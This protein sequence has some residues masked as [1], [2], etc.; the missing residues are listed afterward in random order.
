[1]PEAGYKVTISTSEGRA[2]VGSLR[3]S[4]DALTDATKRSA[5]QQAQWNVR[6]AQQDVIKGVTGAVNV[7]RKA[8]EDLAKIQGVSEK[9]AK[10]LGDRAVQNTA[11]MREAAS[12]ASV[13]SQS[14]GV[15]VTQVTALAGAYVSLRSLASFISEST[16]L[17]A[18]Y[19]TLGVVMHTV[20]ENAGYATS[21]LNG[22]EASLERTGIAMLASRQ[23]VSQMIQAQMD[24]SSATKLAR[25]A[26]DAAVIGN[27]NSSEAF[28]R[29]TTA[30]QTAQPE[31]LRTMGIIVN[32]DEAYRK[33]AR[34][35]STTTDALTENQK[36]QA[37]VAASMEATK[38]IAGAYEA[39]MGTP[40]KQALSLE[41]YWEDFKVNL[42]ESFQP[43][44]KALI[45][46]TTDALKD[47]TEV[48]KDPS[49]QN[50]MK[51]WAESL[52]AVAKAMAEIGKWAGI[53]SQIGT[54]QEG[55]KLLDE[56]RVD[57]S[58]W[59]EF[60]SG[61]VFDFS[62]EN[63]WSNYKNASKRQQM[64]DA[65]KAALERERR[66][67]LAQNWGYVP[68]ESSARGG[69]PF[70]SDIPKDGEL[71]KL[72]QGQQARE[73]YDLK[74][75]ISIFLDKNK[76]YQSTS[77]LLDEATKTWTGERSNASRA[78][79]L[80]QAMGDSQMYADAQKMQAEADQKLIE[81]RQQLIKANEDVRRSIQGIVASA[82]AEQAEL[83]GDKYLSERIK[84]VQSYRDELAQLTDRMA[85]YKGEDRDALESSG[86]RWVQ[87][88]LRISE[89]R[90]ELERW[91]DTLS[92][93]GDL[94]SDLGRLSGSP[95]ASYQG[96][97]FKL[98]AQYKDASD[99]AK[100][101]GISQDLVD[102]AY[103]L[104]A[105]EAWQ[106]SYKGLTTIDG[107]AFDVRRAMLSREVEDFRKAGADET[108]LRIYAAQK[109]EDIAR[110]E[111]QTRQAYAGS[112]T[113]F[114]RGQVNIEL[115]LYQGA[116][117][118]ELQEWQDYYNDLKQLGQ[119]WMDTTKSGL[120]DLIDG[121]VTG[122]GEDAWKNMLANMRR[123][124]IQF[125]VDLAMDWAKAN[126]FK[127]ALGGMLGISSNETA[128]K[129]VE[130]AARGL[131]SQTV[132]APSS[133]SVLAWLGQ[134]V[135]TYTPSLVEEITAP[136]KQ[137]AGAVSKATGGMSVYLPEIKKAADWYGLPP[138]LIQS[139]VYHESRGNPNAVSGKGAMGLMQLMPGTAREMGVD[140][141]NPVENIWGGTKF[142]AMMK[143]RY[144]GDL[145]KALAAYNA[146][147]GAVDAGTVPSSTWKYNEKVFA[148]AVAYRSHGAADLSSVAALPGHHLEKLNQTFADSLGSMAKDFEQITGEKLRLTDGFRTRA[149]QEETYRNKPNLAAR[150]GYSMHEYGYAVD[151]DSAQAKQVIDL[152]NQGRLDAHGLD[153]LRGRTK[154]EPWHWQL[155]E[156]YSRQ[157]EIRNG[158]FVAGSQPYG[159]AGEEG[160]RAVA[161]AAS[162]YGLLGVNF[163]QLGAQSI[164][165]KIDTRG[166]IYSALTG[167][168][169]SYAWNT[170]NVTQASDMGS[171][172]WTA[173]TGSNVWDVSTSSSALS[174]LSSTDATTAAKLV[175]MGMSPDQAVTLVTGASGGSSTAQAVNSQTAQ[176]GTNFN[177]SD[178]LKNAGSG[179]WVDSLNQ[180]GF[181]NLGIG[182]ITGE[183]VG[184]SVPA[185][186]G[187]NATGWTGST[188]GLGTI[189]AGA[190]TGATTG[191]GISSLVY[192]NGTGTMGGTLGGLAG[193]ALGSAL[194][195]STIGG[196]IGGIVG[197]LLGSVL[198][199][200]ETKKTEKTGSGVTVN[201]TN[202][203]VSQQ[204]YSTY[205]T[206]TSG[207]FGS[208][209]TSHSKSYDTVGDPELESAFR[210]ALDSYT[211][212]NWRSSVNMGI[213]TSALKS[214]SFPF[215]FDIDSENAS[216]AAKAVAN[217]QAYQIL[218]SAGIRGEVDDVL[219]SGEVYVD[220]LKRISDAYN[221]GSI[222]AAA[223]GTSLEKLSGT[224][225]TVFQG[226]WFSDVAD[227]LGGT[228]QASGAFSTYVKYGLSKT[229][230]VDYALS[231][232][233]GGAGSAIAQLGDASVNMGNFWG[234]Y[235][236]AMNAG[237]MSADQFALWAN[238]A[239]Y[240]SSYSDTQY[241]AL[242]LMQTINNVRIAQLKEEITEIQNVKVMVDGLNTSISSAYST[243]KN[244]YDTL[245]SS[246]Q[247][248]TWS[249]SLSTNT[250]TQ[251]FKQ[252]QAYYN[253]LKAKVANEDSSS[254]TYS[255]DVSKL[256]SFS[257][258][259]LQTAKSYYGASSQYYKIYNEVTGTLT[260]LQSSTKTE[261]DYL[262][263][264]LQAQYTVINQN[265]AQID[266]LTLANTNL[267]ILG[268]GLDGLGANISGGL[269]AIVDALGSS[270]SS[271]WDGSLS[272]AMD[273]YA[274]AYAATTA[275]LA[276]T[277]TV[278][279]SSL[280]NTDWSSLSTLTGYATGGDPAAGEWA[281]VG[282]QGPEL[283][284]FGKD[285]RVYNANETKAILAAKDGGNKATVAALQQNMQVLGAGFSALMTKFDA[286]ISEN[287]Q[288]RI[289]A[290]R[291]RAK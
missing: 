275:S 200:S 65:A 13:L 205:R 154:T 95:E 216:F 285:A 120:V 94:M 69:S 97:M 207:M 19:G 220:A 254:L 257:Q 144:G 202:G 237:N 39:A 34:T 119:G 290:E 157:E 9:E 31:M 223:A 159:P 49:F 195:G 85:T 291:Q 253:K 48:V 75:T 56:G 136:A 100:A 165:S 218:D 41:R 190:L 91:K 60:T 247:S 25:S 180:W 189:A 86:R 167:D 112:F 105:R 2:E 224:V 38:A 228:S 103:T 241:Q 36:M 11:Q 248:I 132:S 249:S 26:Q 21:E 227:L 250:P 81:T 4:M 170:S 127:P 147:P 43:A 266:Q 79:S 197:G 126:V 251:T 63:S 113:D 142:L 155:A 8:V 204:G 231:A 234:K 172:F 77:A 206:T 18:R 145:N 133:E 271:S 71:G 194:L 104:K 225:S 191:F 101:L 52:G 137:A 199:G 53:R 261:L 111:L 230:A 106:E 258:T 42:G 244:L 181:E 62:G 138:Q 141:A 212:Q 24:L 255:S 35:I 12:S 273:A 175:A 232:Y 178:L 22:Y 182:S 276:T 129:T 146:G 1:M 262:S 125:A 3:Q 259:Y 29:M 40:G 73:A 203:N 236:E 235:Q 238:A 57:G 166:G 272:A 171:S 102:Q 7:Y 68:G 140:A 160:T 156:T 183:Q 47:F 163:G 263:E 55:K 168:S 211:A 153:Y 284:R 279:T 143:E 179:S 213:S 233:A 283:V 242:D 208:T 89:A 278:D 46:G 243:Y 61:D 177:A 30:I 210:S 50:S 16:T 217:Y 32:F 221:A 260:N 174:G 93:V 44:Y 188:A 87:E 201:I 269:S 6:L 82:Q 15:L 169:A 280:T 27:I 256:S 149:Q 176:Q 20:G 193:G 229:Q 196:P 110:D 123:Q 274:S 252:Q 23:S 99:Q 124:F 164:L 80:A 66:D 37:R 70:T 185:F 130:G 139:M 107:S 150:P 161:S 264:Q 131:A 184:N 83:S 267:Q 84:A 240:M 226:D 268:A 246:I 135:P 286:L 277:A 270:W 287:R 282:E 162:S 14:L 152:I 116:H 108:A 128:T 90:I 117:S 265:Q 288:M 219:K 148:D 109:A 33:Y 281:Y 245:T 67:W 122:K 96:A 17:A 59:K 118:R 88:K 45:E 51:D 192:P 239:S 74:N 115:G 92:T 121:A 134:G 198:G 215:D 76:P 222:A 28:G 114:L 98:K 186:Q 289:V 10:A 158:S 58:W 64:V 173:P 209:S 54:L 5:E 72:F 151:I 214:F 78:Q 187:M